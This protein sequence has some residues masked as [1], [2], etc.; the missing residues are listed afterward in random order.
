M[1]RRD[2]G[3]TL[4]EVLMALFFVALA[5][6]IVARN[7]SNG[8]AAAQAAWEAR[9]AL[10]VAR[11]RLAEI[12]ASET[13]R[14]GRSQGREPDGIKWETTITAYGDTQP[15]SLRAY[16]VRVKAWPETASRDTALSLQTI[17]TSLSHA[18]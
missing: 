5:T 16:R 15:G 6:A 8:R 13:L 1:L 2:H 18:Q 7:I 9:Q 14:E 10:A 11:S 4:L 12:G 17:K 3:F